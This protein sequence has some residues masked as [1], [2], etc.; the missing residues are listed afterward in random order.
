VLAA[1]GYSGAG[2]S[3]VVEVFNPR[4]N[5]WST[6]AP[7]NRGRY[8]HAQASLADGRVLVSGGNP[9]TTSAEIYDPRTNAWTEVA[10][11]N[12]GRQGHAMVALP[13]GAIA[14]IGGKGAETSIE[15]YEPARDAWRRRADMPRARP[16]PLAAVLPDGRILVT[17]TVPETDIYD[18]KLDRWE[19]APA[20]SAG[21]TV[22]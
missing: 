4:T 7:L 17:G 5:S 16:A 15:F 18:P 1:G 11:L 22:R 13:G 20:M 9:A 21:R 2:I 6:V 19:S 14:A 8:L 3:G 12:Q 10:A